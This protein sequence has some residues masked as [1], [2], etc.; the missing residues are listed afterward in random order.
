MLSSR[1]K[2]HWTSDIVFL[3]L[4]CTIFYALW[5]GSYALFT[6]DEGRYSE[7]AREMVTTG[8]YITPRL[9]GV[10][11][12][13][14]PIFYYWLQ[15]FAIKTFGLKEWALRL[16]P[17]LFGIFGAVITYICTRILA[18]RQ[19]GIFAAIIL[20]TCPLYYGAAHYANLDLEVAVLIATTLFL[21]GVALHT[22]TAAMRSTLFVLAYLFASL[23]FLTK[24]LIGVVFP[25]LVVGLWILLTN[26]WRIIPKMKILTGLVIFVLINLPWYYYAQ[27][28]NPQ[29]LHFFFITQQ[30][31][32][33]L[34]QG[35]YNNQSAPWFYLPIIFIGVF[36]WTLFIFQAIGNGVKTWWQNKT[37][38]TAELYF[39]IWLTVVFL[40][41]SIPKSKTIGYIIPCIPP[42]AALV[43]I[44]FSQAWKKLNP[45]FALYIGMLGYIVCGFVIATLF[46]LS[47]RYPIYGD[48]K[49][50]GNYL[51]LAGI[52]FL[53]ASILCF[54]FILQKQFKR[55]IYCITLSAILFLLIL[56]SSAQTINTKS[57]K[58]LAKTLVTNLKPE[59]E[60]V[61]YYSYYHDLPLY[62]QKRVTIV[63]NWNSPHIIEN[64]N[65]TREMWFGMPFQDTKEWLISENIFWNRW[66]SDKKLVVLID[67][68]ELDRFAKRAN[69][70]VYSMDN[71]KDF[72]VVSNKQT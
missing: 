55:I 24:G 47:S 67:K 14:K 30:V 25:I 6:P 21:A 68:I 50:L 33:F 72:L 61:T 38:N 9:N 66:H 8:D 37:A 32:R 13:D 46:F 23:A 7:I 35:A 54:V 65:W 12:L 11:F 10:A 41:F 45:P 27:K 22:Q 40:F 60:F 29:F 58:P 48:L 42:I 4:G 69:S 49:Y 17:M 59:D 62:L 18:N 39:L 64:D 56:I 70:P 43:G 71:Y 31:S 52:N 34:T 1:T 19:S 57:M 15:A 26:Q 36:P 3:L 5:L 63:A 53:V 44:Y 2:S 16:W 51:D 20:A 28:A